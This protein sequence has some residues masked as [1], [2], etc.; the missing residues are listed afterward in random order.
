MP[1]AYGLVFK[2]G[3]LARPCLTVPLLRRNIRRR[4]DSYKPESWHSLA[5]NI[6]RYKT[7][8]F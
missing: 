2:K 1:F 8:R 6:A 7:Q 4:G 3:C 5:L